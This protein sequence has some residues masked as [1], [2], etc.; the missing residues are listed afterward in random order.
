MIFHDLHIVLERGNNSSSSPMFIVCDICYWCA[1]CLDKNRRPKYYCP[2][3]GADNIELSIFPIL[4][5][6]L[7]AS[8]SSME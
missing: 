1:T 4:H 7:L 8:D 6:E 5:N 2:Q 3:C